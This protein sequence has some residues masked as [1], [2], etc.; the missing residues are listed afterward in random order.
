MVCHY[1]FFVVSLAVI[2]FGGG[3]FALLMLLFGGGYWLVG[4]LCYLFCVGIGGYWV[5]FEVLRVV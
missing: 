1:L 3:L 2:G 5:V 4:G